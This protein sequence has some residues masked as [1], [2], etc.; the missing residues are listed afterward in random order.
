[1]N[2]FDYAR[3]DTGNLVLLEHLNLTIPDQ[4]AATAFYVSGLGLTRDPY[5]MTGV[6]NMWINVGRSQIHLPHGDAQRLRGHVG[7]IVGERQSLVERL[8]AVQPLLDG[9]AFG[10]TERD[11]RVE[12]NCPW[13]NRYDCLDPETYRQNAA[14]PAIDLGMAYVQL[15]VPAGC[16]RPIAAF[17]REMFNTPVELLDGGG[18]QQAVIAIGTH[19]QL[20]YAETLEANPEYDGHHIQ[21]Y[22][23][24]FSGPYAR[25]AERGLVYGEEPH[26]YRFAT[27]IDPESGADCFKLEHEVRSLHHPLYARP[28]VNRNPDQGN[29]NY[30]KGGDRRNGVF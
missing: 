21:V 4:R 26:Q 2:R 24:N 16:A 27:L 17:Y 11:D 9:T 3:E 10:W 18:L 29:R 19:Q 30:R 14:G 13:G 22:V 1:M 28:L 8:R 23:S 15:D 12:V 25:L 6:T 7:L 20:I 5:L